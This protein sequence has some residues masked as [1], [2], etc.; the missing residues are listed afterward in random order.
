MREV[1]GSLGRIAASLRDV[2][3]TLKSF[4]D[5]LRKVEI[6]IARVHGRLQSMPSTWTLFAAILATVLTVTS[7]TFAIVRFGVPN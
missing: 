3:S 5:R 1:K 7:L 6:D 4:D 2:H